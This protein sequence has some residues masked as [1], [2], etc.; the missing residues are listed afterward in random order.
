[1]RASMT[2]LH[3]VIDSARSMQNQLRST[4]YTLGGQHQ[5]GGLGAVWSFLQSE[6]GKDINQALGIVG[7]LFDE[8]KDFQKTFKA[9]APYVDNLES[10]GKAIDVIGVILGFA[11][12]K[13]QN[14][15]S[16]GAVIIGF[17]IDEGA[18]H[19]AVAG[20]AALGVVTAPE[21]VAVGGVVAMG[22]AAYTAV[23][24]V[25]NLKGQIDQSMG[26]SMSSVDPGMGHALSS[27]GKD[28]VTTS[29]NMDY[30]KVFDD[31]GYYVMDSVLT[32][33]APVVAASLATDAIIGFPAGEMLFTTPAMQ[34]DA[35]H[36][37]GD[38]GR[39]AASFV[40][41]GVDSVAATAINS[42]ADINL[43]AHTIPLPTPLSAGVI[44]LTDSAANAFA[45]VANFV[46]NRDF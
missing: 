43:M 46:T 8:A 36:L 1:M 2:M 19:A 10:A 42:L 22:V 45:G 23:R 11:T 6:I 33:P 17:V 44:H 18:Q 3:F 20:L 40:Q 32:R 39:L 35:T 14:L 27:V 24:L 25:T 26:S 21:D 28:L 34:N 13:E 7:P 9:L 31:V 29:D 4:S 30:Q 37:L 38:T 12:Q 16:A 5:S 41:I 15:R